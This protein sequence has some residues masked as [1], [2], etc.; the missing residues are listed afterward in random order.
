MDPPFPSIHPF[1]SFIF[2]TMNTVYVYGDS[3]SCKLDLST[4]ETRILSLSLDNQ[5][6]NQRTNGPVWNEVVAERWDATL[7]NYAQPGATFCKHKDSNNSYLHQQVSMMNETGGTH[8]IFLGIHDIISTQEKANHIKEW[9]D[10][11]HTG[12]LTLHEKEAR[13]IVMGLPALEFSPYAQQKDEKQLKTLIMDYNVE[14]EERVGDWKEQGL[15]VEFF[16][17]YLVFS[18]LLGDPAPIRDVDHAYWDHCVGRCRDSIDDYLWYDQIHLTGSGHRAMA[19]A[20]L[21][22]SYFGI[23]ALP[24]PE[25]NRSSHGWVW[26]VVVLL[27]VSL[28]GF[29]LRHHPFITKLKKKVGLHSPRAHRDVEYVPV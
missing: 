9:V 18:D 20:L 7:V 16:D 13:V 17:S 26:L 19:N 8:I 2:V 12:I 29:F 14:L 23:I 25:K 11:V 3:Y 1:L 6:D 28:A 10:C 4:T 15:G 5:P 27:A 22:Q 24:P 21:D